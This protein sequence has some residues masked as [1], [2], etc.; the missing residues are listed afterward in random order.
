MA[1]VIYIP[2]MVPHIP[3]AM[4]SKCKQVAHYLIFLNQ[5]NPSSHM[6]GKLW[7]ILLIEGR[8]PLSSALSYPA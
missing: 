5:L 4:F 7:H 6:A 8:P 3:G 1:N 2:H